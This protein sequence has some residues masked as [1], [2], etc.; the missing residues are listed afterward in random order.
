MYFVKVICELAYYDEMAGS[1][2][3]I[4]TLHLSETSTALW[5]LENEATEEQRGNGM[6]HRIWSLGI[7]GLE[8]TEEVED[9]EL[10][11]RSIVPILYNIVTC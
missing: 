9:D 11:N 3:T 4:A 8:W 7:V 5:D 1:F 6:H 10:I 2:V